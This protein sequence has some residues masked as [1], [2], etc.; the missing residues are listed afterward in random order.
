[1]KKAKALLFYSSIVLFVLAIS[2]CSTDNEDA[3]DLMEDVDT[4]D[5]E[6]SDD[7]GD[8]DEMETNGSIEFEDTFVLD[9]DRMF[10]N[11]VLSNTEYNK[12]LEGEGDIQMVSNKVYEYFNDEF[13]F[14]FIL[15][16]E[17]EQPSGLYFGRSSS[18]KNDIDGLGASLWDNTAS[19]GS[20]GTL[21]TIIH[22]PRTEYVLNGPFLHEIAHYWANHGLIETTVG[23]HWGY[24]SVGGQLGGFDELEDLGNNTY[25]GSLNG[26]N[27][28]G[29]FANGGNSV[30]YGN[31]EL[32]AM[33]L[34]AAD[35]L[36]TVQIAE[37]PQSTQEFG[38]FTTDNI[39]S[40]TA[41]DIVSSHG[42]RVP[43]PQNAQ[44]SF[45]GITI[46]IS[47][48][49]IDQEKTDRTTLD[50]QNFARAGEPD[51]YW[52]NTYNFWK[53][54]EGRATLTIEIASDDIK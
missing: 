25:R 11:L 40:L 35:E 9:A 31:L 34:I 17:E 5:Q 32:Y 26:Q 14:I 18:A 45:K 6:G 3:N 48:E 28:F 19:Y 51:A 33:G 54:T 36:E 47:T 7:E 21:K 43:S 1:M 38:V 37:N 10:A 42:E 52:G 15:S 39:I 41:A 22:M 20:Q 12:F 13:D 2:S 53:A 50:L 27:G 29:T 4:S 30:P 46:I 49:S 23:G 44:R 16:V 8:P 24:A